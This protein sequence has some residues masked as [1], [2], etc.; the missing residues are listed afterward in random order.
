LSSLGFGAPL[1]LLVLAVIG[2]MLGYA[3]IRQERDRV[4]RLHRFGDEPLLQQTSRVPSRRWR[5]VRDLLT[6]AAVLLIL[7][8]LAR[9]QL[10]E[11][12]SAMGRT[13][14]DLL[15]VLDL[16]RS[17]NAADVEQSRLAVAK[18]LVRDLLRA[19]PGQRVGLV[20]FGGS[21]FLQLPLTGNY[22]AF[23][24]FLDAASTDDLGDPAT[25]LSNALLAANTAFEHDGERGYQTVLL[26]SDGESTG[27]IGPVLN[28]LRQARIPVLAVGVGT[29]QGAPVPADSSEAP[30]KWHRDNIGR[31]VLSRLEEG[32]LR[33]AARETGGSYYQWS[34]AIAHDL[35]E[36]L[37]RLDRRAITTADAMERVD[38]FQWP[39]GFAIGLLVLI[40][41]TGGRAPRTEP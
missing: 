25:D 5:M 2:P 29:M 40:P 9:P 10:G 38:R 1:Y 4:E 28:R 24:R 32:D 3:L 31:I 7:L 35:S 12:P 6:L 36:S 22:A 19:S 8:A 21:A 30:D 17:M 13:G 14:R 37:S 18:Q 20:V 16:S 23:Q 15:V 34:P 41:L 39:L 27:D 33:R 11:R 26:V